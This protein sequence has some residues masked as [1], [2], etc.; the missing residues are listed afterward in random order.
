MDQLHKV[1]AS[2]NQPAAPTG[3]VPVALLSLSPGRRSEGN[4][5]VCGEVSRTR[6]VS[7]EEKSPW[8]GRFLQ[9]GQLLGG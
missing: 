9:G 4:F 2:N 6:Q 3:L 8:L 5:M 1:W 7:L